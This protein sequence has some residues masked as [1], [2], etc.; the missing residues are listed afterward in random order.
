MTTGLCDPAWNRAAPGQCKEHVPYEGFLAGCQQA[1]TRALGRLLQGSTPPAPTPSPKLP[2]P[3]PKPQILGLFGLWIH[4]SIPYYL[5]LSVATAI[6]SSLWSLWC[7]DPDLSASNQVTRTLTV[8]RAI[9]KCTTKRMGLVPRSWQS[10]TGTL[11][12]R[13]TPYPKSL[14]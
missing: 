13:H 11:N 9:P 12:L 1:L 7:W 5:P 2:T 3:N 6:G 8:V 4:C 10:S 14:K